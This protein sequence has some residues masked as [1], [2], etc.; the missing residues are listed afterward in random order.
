MPSAAPD[1][2]VDVVLLS[3]N[4]ME[5]LRACIDGMMDHTYIPSRLI[6]VD[7]ASEPEVRAMLATI[8]PQGS[9]QAVQ[10]IQ[11]E[12]N[13]GFSRGMNAGIQASRAPFVCLL[14]NDTV[15]A[16]GWL[17]RM[18]EVA[19]QHEDIGILNPDSNTFG[20][21]VPPGM[22]L[23]D[24]AK[25]LEPRRGEFLEAGTC[26]GFCLLI[27]RAVVERIGLLDESIGP[28]FYEDEDYGVRA[29]EAGFRSVVVPSA[30]VYHVE[31][32]S[33]N[34]LPEREAIYQASRRRFR[35]KWG[36]SLRVAYCP[37]RRLPFGSPEL[38]EA[39]TRAIGWARRRATVRMMFNPAD[40]SADTGSW[41]RSV[42]LTPHLDVQLQ[43]ISG[44]GVGLR[45][46][47]RIVSRRKKR[48]DLIVTDHGSL[49]QV[50][51]GWAWL[52]G[53]DVVLESDTVRLQ[54]RWNTRSRCL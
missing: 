44:R 25:L 10:V 50:L 49:A 24:Y 17:A 8:K 38:Q 5:Q 36:K 29:L 19:D 18:I 6:I 3:W 52:H 42:G 45:M 16:P 35:E 33:V 11:N 2:Q 9:I 48:Y 28:F 4:S 40:E 53:A 43:A 32:H 14:N 21:H 26:V 22:T 20:T 15:P 7:N 51:R 47:R 37:T 27:K 34:H 41:F 31:H 46:L 54:E 23:P 12:R 39:L 1:V 30:Y 13:E